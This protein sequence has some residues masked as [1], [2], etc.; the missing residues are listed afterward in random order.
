[1]TSLNLELSISI[2]ELRPVNSLPVCFST[3]FV[4]PANAVDMPPTVVAI[5][6]QPRKVRSFAAEMSAKLQRS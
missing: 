1:M 5:L 4:Y 2:E 6:S 3:E